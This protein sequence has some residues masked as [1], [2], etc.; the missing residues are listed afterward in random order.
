VELFISYAIKNGFGNTNVTVESSNLTMEDIRIIEDKWYKKFG[1]K[2][3][4]LN[5]NEL[6]QQPKEE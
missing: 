2:I 1:E 5:W 6:T 4:L 3:V